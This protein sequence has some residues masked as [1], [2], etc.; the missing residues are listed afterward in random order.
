VV[1]AFPRSPDPYP[2]FDTTPKAY[3]PPAGTEPIDS[4][5]D[6]FVKTTAILEALHRS[7]I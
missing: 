1:D 5:A 3:K 4:E 7:T 2:A 6:I